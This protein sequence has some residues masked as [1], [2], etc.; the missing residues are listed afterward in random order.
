MVAVCNCRFCY[1]GRHDMNFLDVF[2]GKRS[3]RHFAGA[4]RRISL[5]RRRVRRVIRRRRR[6]ASKASRLQYAEHKETTRTLVSTRLPEIIDAYKAIGIEFK[7]VG[8]ICIKNTLTRW[9]SCSSKGNLN[10]SYRLCLLPKHLSDYIII[11]ELCHLREFN[12]SSRFW[13]LVAFFAPAYAA[14][15]EEL[16]KHSLR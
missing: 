16:K 12:H 7:P 10:F 1:T 13:D 3:G 11:H 8:R 9:G 6:V 5:R 14:H 15:R 2:I 4:I